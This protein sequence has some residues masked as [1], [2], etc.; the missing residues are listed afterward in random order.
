MQARQRT[1]EAERLLTASRE[2]G[3]DT[4]EVLQSYGPD[5]VVIRTSSGSRFLT[6]KRACIPQDKLK[7]GTRVSVNA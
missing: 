2:P 3:Q 7:P 1:S 4:A 5:E 6:N